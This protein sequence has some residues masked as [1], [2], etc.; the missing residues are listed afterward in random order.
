MVRSLFDFP[1][2]C[3][4]NFTEP[5][6]NELTLCYTVSEALLSRMGDRHFGRIGQ[7]SKPLAQVTR[8]NKN[9]KKSIMFVR[10]T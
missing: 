3:R 1:G 5:G 2:G 8:E 9:A 4:F 10:S 6:G 7:L